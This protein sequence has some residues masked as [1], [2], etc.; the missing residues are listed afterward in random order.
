MGG[1]A[2]AFDLSPSTRSILNVIF[3]DGSRRI[4]AMS[5]KRQTTE[6]IVNKLRQADV[7]LAKGQTIASACKLI[8]ITDQTYFRWRREYGGLKVDQDKRFKEQENARLK[9]LVAEAELDKA[10]LREAA[11]PNF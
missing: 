9:R 4:K 1:Q 7:E 6:Q 10:I 3:W 2:A 8:G 5:Q 11:R